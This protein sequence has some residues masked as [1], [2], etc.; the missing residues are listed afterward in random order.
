M[1]STKTILRDAAIVVA[2]S[3]VIALGVNEIRSDG[4]PI[5]QGEAH[6][7]LVPCPAEKLGPTEPVEVT[8][9]RVTQDGTLII[10]A[11]EAELYAEWHVEGAVNVFYDLLE[12][13]PEYRETIKRLLHTHRTAQRV[14]VYGDDEPDMK[15]QDGKP[16]DEAGTGFRLAGALSAQGMR[17]VLY[18]L[19]GAS[20]MMKAHRPGG[21]P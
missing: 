6:E 13:T 7:I 2:G 21:A 18:V 15:T 9:A 1:S 16:G 3:A 4:I 11:R 17:N 5:V 20:A 14:V 19:G 12:E 10:D 8:D